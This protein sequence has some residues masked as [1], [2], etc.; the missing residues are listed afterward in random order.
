MM[1]SMHMAQKASYFEQVSIRDLIVERRGPGDRYRHSMR[2]YH[3]LTP[4]EQEQLQADWRASAPLFGQPSVVG[5][6]F[7]Q[8]RQGRTELVEDIIPGVTERQAREL[9]HHVWREDGRTAVAAT[10][11]I[12]YM[13]SIYELAVIGRYILTHEVI[14]ASYKPLGEQRNFGPLTVTAFESPE[15]S[16]AHFDTVADYSRALRDIGPYRQSA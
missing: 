8:V 5:Y 12:R 16:N 1:F 10:A 7:D 9:F 15:A 14:K 2:P 6:I 3:E 13:P 4:E 11:E